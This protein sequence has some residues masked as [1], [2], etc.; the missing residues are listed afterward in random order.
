[1]SS[2]S[3]LSAGALLYDVLSTDAELAQNCTK[4]FPVIAEDTA[5]LPYI[6]FSRSSL[7]MSPVKSTTAMSGAG[8]AIYEVT[9][10]SGTYAQSM[11]M[12]ERVCELLDN[13]AY[14]YTDEE[15]NQTLTARSITLTG[16]EETWQGDAYA[17]K[18]S[19]Q[20]KVQ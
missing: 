8:T 4:V 2:L 20:I 10:Y 18:L 16:A 7:Q 3:V 1:M 9:C 17:Q 5:E 15:N 14:Q 12:A 19:F 11:V 6:E 13:Q